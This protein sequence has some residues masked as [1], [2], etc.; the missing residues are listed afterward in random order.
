MKTQCVLN[1]DVMAGLTTTLKV[2]TSRLRFSESTILMIVA[3]W[4][5]GARDLAKPACLD[6]LARPLSE[7]GSWG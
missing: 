5:S 4:S 7:H 6:Q 2:V 1:V 3:M